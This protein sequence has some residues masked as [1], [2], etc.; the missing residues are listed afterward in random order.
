MAEGAK[1]LPKRVLPHL[2]VLYLAATW[3]QCQVW[4]YRVRARRVVDGSIVH[5]WDVG[6]RGADNFERRSF[7]YI[8]STSF[9]FLAL[10]PQ[11]PAGNTG[12]C[13]KVKELSGLFQ[14][15]SSLLCC[16]ICFIKEHQ[17]SEPPLARFTSSVQISFFC[18]YQWTNCS[19]HRFSHTHSR[20]EA[21]S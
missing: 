12:V 19:V 1:L 13:V 16:D 21:V 4:I 10:H 15:L 5:V 20:Q 18:V 11:R 9:I 3:Q 17:Q 2:R 8:L 7:F 6:R 14:F